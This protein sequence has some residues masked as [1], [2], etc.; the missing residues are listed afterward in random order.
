MTTCAAIALALKAL[1]AVDRY[2]VTQHNE[3]YKGWA[4]IAG[5]RKMSVQEAAELLSHYSHMPVELITTQHGLKRAYQMAAAATH[6]DNRSSGSH[7]AFVYVQQA[8]E[9]IEKS[10]Y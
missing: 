4:Q 3:Q 2:G 10:L 5:P 9:I 6:P 7:E 1:R 8:R